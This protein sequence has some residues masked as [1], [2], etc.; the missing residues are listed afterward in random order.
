MEVDVST[1][2]ARTFALQIEVVSLDEDDEGAINQGKCT[3]IEEEK[4][5]QSHFFSNIEKSSSQLIPIESSKEP[6]MMIQRFT[7]DQA[8]S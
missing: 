3:M 5:D 6:T 8:E 4:D 1:K 2:R 7:L